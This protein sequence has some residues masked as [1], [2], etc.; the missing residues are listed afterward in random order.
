[1]SRRQAPQPPVAEVAAPVEA[2]TAATASTTA[3]TETKAARSEYMQAVGAILKLAETAG[4]TILLSYATRLPM[5]DDDEAF[6]KATEFELVMACAIALPFVALFV[7]MLVNLTVT[8]LNL[9]SRRY[10]YYFCCGLVLSASLL[11][12]MPVKVFF[13]WLM[14]ETPVSRIFRTTVLNPA[15][16]DAVRMNIVFWGLMLTL[17]PELR[18]AFGF[19]Q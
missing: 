3:N 1:M 17:V 14:S 7:A 10:G 13:T 4:S 19:H 18:K 5:G 12:S 9:A 16:G 6:A 11:A 2:A 15:C 8:D